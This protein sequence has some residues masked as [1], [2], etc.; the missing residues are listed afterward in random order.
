MKTRLTLFIGLF[1]AQG[2]AGMEDVVSLQRDAS[3]NF[4]VV[5]ERSGELM[6]LSGGIGADA[7]RSNNVCTTDTAP[8]APAILEEGVYSTGAEFCSQAIAWKGEQLEIRVNPPCS[9]TLLM[10]RFDDGWYRGKLRGYEYLYELEVKSTVSYVFHSR[11]FAKQA[12]FTKVTET[13]VPAPTLKPFRL[14]A[15]PLSL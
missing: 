13:P 11:S 15:D 5:C 3:G 9:G 4:N 10:D 7:I 1:C 6:A 8:S 2:F 14:G 12:E